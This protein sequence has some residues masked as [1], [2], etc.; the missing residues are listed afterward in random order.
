[1]FEII[2]LDSENLNQ[3][4]RFLIGTQEAS[5]NVTIVYG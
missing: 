3:I 4:E 2:L 1:M 5:V